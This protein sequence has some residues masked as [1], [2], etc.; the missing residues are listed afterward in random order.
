MEALHAH[1]VSS[2]SGDVVKAFGAEAGISKERCLANLPGPGRPA[3]RGPQKALRA[4]PLP[5]VNLDATY[6]TASAE[7][8]VV[9]RVVLIATGITEDG[10]NE[11]PRPAGVM[12]PM[13]V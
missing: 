12:S 5:H 6:S 7:H 11:V 10:G 4:H 2:R 9:S 8:Q 13:A 1:N 3:D